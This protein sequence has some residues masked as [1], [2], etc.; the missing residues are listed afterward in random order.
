MIL[1][2][3]IS[4]AT[5][6]TASYFTKHT[7]EEISYLMGSLTFF[8]L[9]LSLILAPWQIKLI[10]L[11]IV[12]ISIHRFWQHIGSDKELETE[13]Q[14]LKKSQHSE[15]SK[16][17]KIESKYRGVA[18][19]PHPETAKVVEEELTGKYRGHPYHITHHQPHSTPQ[20]QF[21]LK[22]RGVNITNHKAQAS[23][24]TDSETD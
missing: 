23:Q 24:D 14:T 10:I 15:D 8:S 21:E 1:L 6:I 11:I 3:N 18:Y 9:L 7:S 4:L 17:L 19:Q 22:Y 20:P 5:G 2:I 16:Q 12:I 13:Q